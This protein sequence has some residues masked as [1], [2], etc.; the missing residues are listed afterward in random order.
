MPVRTLAELVVKQN[1]WVD[2]VIPPRNIA[3]NNMTMSTNSATQIRFALCKQIRQVFSGMPAP[4]E[5]QPNFLIV[6]DRDHPC[7]KHA[8]S[9]R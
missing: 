7:R 2:P 5:K 6:I 8:F 1:Y 9:F 3:S 4:G